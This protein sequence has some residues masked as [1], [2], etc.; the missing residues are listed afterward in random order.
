MHEHMV[1]LGS[2]DAT[3]CVVSQACC[4]K[5][6]LCYGSRGV[7]LTYAT[8]EY[9][10]RTSLGWTRARPESDER[11]STRSRRGSLSYS[12]CGSSM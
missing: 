11:A 6:C 2:F 4:T 8:L 5:D 9:Q 7:R 12:S 1:Q 3:S 10:D